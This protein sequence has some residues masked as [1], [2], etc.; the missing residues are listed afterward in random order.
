MKMPLQT[1]ARTRRPRR[2]DVAFVRDSVTRACGLRPNLDVLDDGELA[3]LRQLVQEIRASA[4]D[5]VERSD[6][7]ALGDLLKLRRWET[8]VAKAAG[9]PSDFF[10]RAREQA[11][12]DA[13][14]AERKRRPSKHPRLVEAG[15]TQIPAAVFRGMQDGELDATH[16]L[17]LTLVLAMIENGAGL[18]RF[19]QVDGDAV[20]VPTAEHLVAP[21][22]PEGDISG[23]SRAL[24]E[25]GDADVLAVERHG[26]L[27]ISLGGVLADA[28]NRGGGGA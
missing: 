5:D 11:A 24:R 10:D 8:L 15:T 20:V 21:I 25:L 23:V 3:E 18:H 17:V 26:E 22:D 16:L 7:G 9:R 13:A 6:P 12:A 27:R 1:K 28:L 4:D 2:E 19:A 14:K